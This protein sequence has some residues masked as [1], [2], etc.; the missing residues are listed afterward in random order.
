MH[1]VDVVIPHDVPSIIGD[2]A[3]FAR[4][5][6]QISHW[7]L[8]L[9]VM[10]MKQVPPIRHWPGISG[11]V[12]APVESLHVSMVQGC[13]SLQVDAVVHIPPL[14]IPQPAVLPSLQR[15]VRIDHAMVLD[16]V[17]HSW[18]EFVGLTVPSA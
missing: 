17:R 3:M 14:H 2:H 4:M 8:G 12:Q 5:G 6:S 16:D 10:P 9:R 13:A 18:H 15:P 11:N 1:P 7:L